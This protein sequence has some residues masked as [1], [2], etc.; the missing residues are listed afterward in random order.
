MTTLQNIQQLIDENRLQEALSECN[1]L[2]E[3]DSDND[4]LLLLR[5]K[6]H[7]RLQDFSR[8][9]SDFA[10]AVTINPQSEARHL[11]EMAREVYSF[12]NPDLLNP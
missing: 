2:I 4:A 6:I 11:L 3:T 7:W 8:A 5:G 10:K 12:F 9:T 1:A